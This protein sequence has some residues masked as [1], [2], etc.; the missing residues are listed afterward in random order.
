MVDRADQGGRLVGE[1]T[2]REA[3][4]HFAPLRTGPV[5]GPPPPAVRLTRDGVRV[6]PA[7]PL[8]LARAG[9]RAARAVGERVARQP[10]LRLP[11]GRARSEAGGAATRRH[12]HAAHP[13]DRHGARRCRRAAAAGGPQR[14]GIVESAGDAGR[15]SAAGRR[16]TT[17][18]PGAGRQSHRPLPA[19]SH[20]AG[21]R[22]HT[23][24]DRRQRARPLP[25]RVVA[26]IPARHLLPARGAA[27]LPRPVSRHRAGDMVR[28]GNRGRVLRALSRST[29]G[30]SRGVAVPGELARPAARRLADRQSASPAAPGPARPVAPLGHRRRAARLGA[31]PPGGAQRARRGGHREIRPARHRRAVRG[32]P[33]PDRAAAGRRDPAGAAGA[34]EPVGG[35][36]LPGWR[37]RPRRRDRARLHRRSR[38][39]PVPPL[40]PRVPRL[41]AGG[42]GALGRRRRRCCNGPSICS[43]RR[44][45]ASRWCWSSRASASAARPRSAS[46]ASSAATPRPGACPVAPIRRR[47]EVRPAWD[48]ASIRRWVDRGRGR[49]PGRRLHNGGMS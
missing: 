6:E 20:R 27:H 32:T 33:P 41:R 43:V 30:A 49:G 24:A 48:W 31:R 47:P 21:Q 12:R 34:V 39:G 13:H 4:A 3:K 16:R 5:E 7:G 28:T 42:V 10:R 17:S 14:P 44:T 15:R 18:D 8:A 35:A 25:A 29:R 37:L 1:L 40:R 46:T 11:V 9:V 45:P 22:W 38:D 2:R 36:A 26:P 23:G 19:M